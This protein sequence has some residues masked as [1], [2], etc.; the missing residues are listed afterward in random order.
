MGESLAQ[1]RRATELDVANTRYLNNLIATLL[2]SR[3]YDE[4]AAA[5]GE[6]RN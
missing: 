1:S 3:R 6:W 2:E 5:T 4:L